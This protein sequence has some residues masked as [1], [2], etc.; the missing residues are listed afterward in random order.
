[1]KDHLRGQK[2]RR[3]NNPLNRHDRDKHQGVPQSYKMRVLG[4]EQRILPLSVLEGLYIDSQKPGTSL[5]EKNER[6]RGG[7]IRLVATRGLT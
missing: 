3:E 6:G 4:K 7:L 5:N 1:M 2:S